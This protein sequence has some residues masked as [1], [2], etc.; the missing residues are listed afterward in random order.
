MTVTSAGIIG[1]A[2]ICGRVKL[3]N[4][5]PLDIQSSMIK[6]KSANSKKNFTD[7]HQLE[8]TH[9]PSQYVKLVV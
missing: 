7:L 2:Q 8:K 9:I 1:Q 4:G 6:H 3:V 5:I